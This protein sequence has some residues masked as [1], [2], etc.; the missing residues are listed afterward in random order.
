[1]CWSNRRD[2]RGVSPHKTEQNALNFKSPFK[3]R[4]T[5][6]IQL[7]LRHKPY[8]QGQDGLGSPTFGWACLKAATKASKCFITMLVLHDVMILAMD[9]AMISGCSDVGD[10]FVGL[11]W[12]VRNVFPSHS[13]LHSLLVGQTQL[14]QVKH[15]A[16]D[17]EGHNGWQNA[18][19]CDT[20]VTSLNPSLN[21]PK[22]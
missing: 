22:P 16:E 1:M 11:C 20:N 14:R 19:E 7:A 15:Q 10:L 5:N 18:G 2:V 9:L 12:P 4:N 17:L 21:I 3:E 13:H 6:F 8:L